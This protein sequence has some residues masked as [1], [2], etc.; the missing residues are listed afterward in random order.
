MMVALI[1]SKLLTK[2]LTDDIYM[3]AR[4]AIQIRLLG[5]GL[6]AVSAFEGLIGTGLNVQDR[7]LNL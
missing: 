3:N 7:A 6:V 1:K 2:L 5:E 4:V